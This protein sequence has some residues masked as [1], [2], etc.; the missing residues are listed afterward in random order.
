MTLYIIV[1]DITI[2]KDLTVMVIEG[3]RRSGPMDLHFINHSNSSQFITN[4]IPQ[5]ILRRALP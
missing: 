4:T 5:V 1:T 2:N 3:L